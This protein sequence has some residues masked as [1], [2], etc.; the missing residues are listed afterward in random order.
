MTNYLN[1]YLQLITKTEER[2]AKTINGINCRTLYYIG[3][4]FII[5]VGITEHDPKC[6]YDLANLWKKNGYTDRFLPTT[7]HITTY[8]T[9]AEGR[10]TGI[11]NIQHTRDGKINFDYMLEATKENIDTLIAECIRLREMDI[12]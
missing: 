11:Y 9:D 5:E 10:C 2:G 1:K 3:D 6:R 8:H 4:S 12:K 7:A